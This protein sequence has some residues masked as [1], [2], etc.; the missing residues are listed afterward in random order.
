[1]KIVDHNEDILECSSERTTNST[2]METNVNYTSF[3]S[4]TIKNIILKSDNAVKPLILIN[5]IILHKGVTA[6]HLDMKMVTIV[7]KMKKNYQ[8]VIIL[9]YTS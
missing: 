4:L 1:M 5:A 2:K 9:K 8:S 6:V 3:L 7:A